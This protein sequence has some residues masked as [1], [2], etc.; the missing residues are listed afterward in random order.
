MW[1]SAGEN[2]LGQIVS[3]DF[4]T[5][6]L[7]KSLPGVDKEALPE[8]ESFTVAEDE[9]FK[10]Q[11]FKLP[12]TVGLVVVDSLAYPKDF[13]DRLAEWFTPYTKRGTTLLMVDSKSVSEN[14]LYPAKWT[15][16]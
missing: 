9:D 3:V 12:K 13:Y 2:L 4:I 11:N 7:W 16:T 8:V 10:N 6:N 15:G 1:L 14:E 5:I